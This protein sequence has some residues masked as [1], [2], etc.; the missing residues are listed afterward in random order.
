MAGAP[1]SLPVVAAV[2]PMASPANTYKVTG[3]NFTDEITVQV[4]ENGALLE[5]LSGSQISNVAVTSFAMDVGPL[6]P[7][8]YSLQVVNADQVRSM[9]FPFT[10]NP[11]R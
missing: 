2:T 9:L 4:F 11:N 1:G 10:V 5:S 3:N 7:G 6:P 8:S